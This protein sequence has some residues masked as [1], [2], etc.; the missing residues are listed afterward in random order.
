MTLFLMYWLEFPLPRYFMN[1]ER[2]WVYKIAWKY[3]HLQDWEFAVLPLKMADW[4]QI[5]FFYESLLRVSDLVLEE[6]KKCF[7]LRV[8][9]MSIQKILKAGNCSNKTLVSDWRAKKDLTEKYRGGSSEP[10][11]LA[12]MSEL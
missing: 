8:R 12:P 2:K 6:C 4:R 5:C 3:M 10:V 9:Q 1:I 11:V 7:G